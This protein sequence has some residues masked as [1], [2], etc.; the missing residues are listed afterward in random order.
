MQE[1]NTDPSL[2]IPA[3]ANREKNLNFSEAEDKTS[4]ESVSDSDRFGNTEEDEERR[5]QW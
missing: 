4:A 3:E 1:K 2:D 5:K